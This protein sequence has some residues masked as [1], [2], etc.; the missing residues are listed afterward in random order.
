MGLDQED[1]PVIRIREL[2]PGI[3]NF[4]W[5]CG[6]KAVHVNLNE[7]TTELSCRIG[8]GPSESLHRGFRCQFLEVRRRAFPGVGVT[9]PLMVLGLGFHKLEVSTNILLVLELPT[10]RYSYRAIY[11]TVRGVPHQI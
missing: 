9:A 1:I 7:T 6:S 3:V 4:A 8:R 10:F 2:D 5:E 11:T